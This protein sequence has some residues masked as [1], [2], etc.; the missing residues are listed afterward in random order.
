MV[1]S[2]TALTCAGAQQ[3]RAGAQVGEIA[4]TVEA[5][6]L[7]SSGS[8]LDQLYLVR[9]LVLHQLDA[10]RRAEARSAPAAAFSLMIFFI[11]ASIF[12]RSSGVKGASKS[13]S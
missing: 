3:M 1:M 5:D 10:P 7:A 12:S 13:K 2:L 6:R 4:L 11:S 8:V 9:L